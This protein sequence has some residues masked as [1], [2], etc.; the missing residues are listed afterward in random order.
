MNENEVV[1]IFEEDG[2]I[3]RGHFLLT[4]GLHSSTF[5]QCSMVMQYPAHFEGL[6]KVLSARVKRL[7]V[8]CVAGPAMGGVILAYEMARALG[9][10]AIYAEKVTE[11]KVPAGAEAGKT[12]GLQF[13]RGFSVRRG[14]RCLVVEDAMTTGDSARAVADLVRA[15]GA[16]VVGVMALV[17]RSGGRVNFGVPF[18]PLLKL[19]IPSY[20]PEECPLCRAGVPLDRPK[21]AAGTA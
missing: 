20:R 10:R 6:C 13:R 3:M 2:V 19:D 14:E 8:E 5:L 11:K 16:E 17:D 12:A 15:K 1:R 9:A 21:S 18:F 7:S 4:S